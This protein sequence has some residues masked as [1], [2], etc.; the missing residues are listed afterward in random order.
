MVLEVTVHQW[1][2]IG[3]NGGPTSDPNNVFS[4]GAS[5]HPNSGFS[6]G[7]KIVLAVTI[8]NTGPNS[9]V[10]VVPARSLVVTLTITLTVV[11]TVT[12]HPNGGAKM[13]LVVPIQQ[14]F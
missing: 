12:F 5:G 4:C 11:L 2:D 14:C 6:S 9:V 7:T 3:F 8:H 13:I 10:A 1:P